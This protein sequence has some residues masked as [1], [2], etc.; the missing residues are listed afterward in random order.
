MYK[1]VEITVVNK[2]TCTKPF[3]DYYSF[4]KNINCLELMMDDIILYN[5]PDATVEQKY[6]SN[7]H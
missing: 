4:E 1:L 7:T 2:F 5:L 6:T 3:F